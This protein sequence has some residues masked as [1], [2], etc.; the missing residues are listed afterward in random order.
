MHVFHIRY[1]N[2]QGTLMRILN[3]ASRRG[4]DM[5]YLQAEPAEHTHKATLLLDVHSKQLGQLCRDWRAIVDVTDVRI[6]APIK[7]LAVDERADWS[8]LM[9]PASAVSLQG[10][11]LGPTA[12][13]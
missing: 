11:E 1:R 12:A 7:D 9:P 13:A 6:S 8:A 5:P 10:G 3:A 4:I 2:T